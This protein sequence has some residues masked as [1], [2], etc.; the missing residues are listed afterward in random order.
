MNGKAIERSH[1]AVLF[2]Y[3]IFNII[4]LM[5]QRH[6]I[7]I[8]CQ[9]ISLIILI[10][11]FHYYHLIMLFIMTLTNPLFVHKG[12]TILL[13][14]PF[15]ITLES[16]LYGFIFGLLIINVLFIFS[17]MNKVLNSEHYIYLFSRYFPHLG[18]LISMTFRLM[19]RTISQYQTINICQKQFYQKNKIKQLLNTFSIEVTSAFESSLVMLDSMKS[20]GY[21]VGKR[22]YFHLFHL[23]HKDILHMI[24]LIILFVLGLVG[25]YI[26]FNQFYFYPMIIL[27]SFSLK[28]YIFLSLFIIIIILPLIWEVNEHVMY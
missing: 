25:Y 22:T 7:V 13:E 17:M 23:R 24:E 6:P 11:K 20:R 26:C 28:E 4:L 10:K 18:L 8:I 5:I 12:I 2:L 19:P 3:F 21:G 14:Y 16:L 9:T 1:P 27:N 15:V